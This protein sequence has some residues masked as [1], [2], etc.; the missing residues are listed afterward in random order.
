MKEREIDT[1]IVTERQSE[2]ETD[3]K[4]EWSRDTFINKHQLKFKGKRKRKEGRE[5]ERIKIIRQGKR[6]ETDAET[7]ER[8]KERK[9]KGDFA[10]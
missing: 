3:R 9:R 4:T 10:C 1:N 5:R 6:K 7:K 2:K 8:K